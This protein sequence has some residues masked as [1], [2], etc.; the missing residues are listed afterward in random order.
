MA[1]GAKTATNAVELVLKGLACRLQL[2]AV[3]HR[4]FGLD[5]AEQCVDHPHPVR[6]WAAGHRRGDLLDR[7]RNLAPPHLLTRFEIIPWRL[8]GSPW[9][10]PKEG[11]FSAD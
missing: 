8:L 9:L 7:G 3:G 6:V 1:G 10:D 2:H 5:H 11:Y 4:R